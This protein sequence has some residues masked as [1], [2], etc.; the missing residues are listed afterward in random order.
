M[1]GLNQNQLLA[2]S[3]GILTGLT[4]M[5]AQLTTLFGQGTTAL[6]AAGSAVV[7]MALS[8]ILTVTSGQGS[9]VKNVLAMPGIE[10]IDVNS[11]ASSTLAAI[12]VDPAQDKIS[13]TPA[14]MQAVTATAKG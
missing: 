7:V 4:G 11:K 9:M 1:F 8:V 2:I 12:A 10:K 6:I 5:T 3:I 14:A 13:P